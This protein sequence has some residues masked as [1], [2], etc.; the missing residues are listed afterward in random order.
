MTRSSRAA[1]PAVA[2]RRAPSRHG[3]KQRLAPGIPAGTFSWASTPQANHWKPSPSHS[4]Q[5][6]KQPRQT[7]QPRPQPLPH[8]RCRPAPVAHQ[9]RPVSQCVISMTGEHQVAGRGGSGEILMAVHVARQAGARA[10]QPAVPAGDPVLGAKITAPGVPGWAVPRPRITELIGQGT[11]SCRLTVV[12]GP[13]GAGKTMALA[14]W[15]AAEPGAV[16]WVGLDGYDNRPGVFWSYAVAALRQAGVA[17]PKALPA[18]AGAG[19]RS[20]VLG[21]ACVGAGGAEPAGD[22]SPRR[23]PSADPPEGAG[24]T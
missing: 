3:G 18:G 16:A 13:P 20:W 17:V 8:R 22:A 24:W 12:T 10:R 9:G 19:G 5:R 2:P 7:K 21:A 6:E 1:V 23:P 14:L 11:R 15:A 4:P